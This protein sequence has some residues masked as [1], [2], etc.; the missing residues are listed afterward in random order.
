MYKQVNR[1]LETT[2][3][4]VGHTLTSARRAAKQGAHGA[5]QSASHVTKSARSST[6][7]QLGSIA[8]MVNPDTHKS[9][10]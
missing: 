7:R 1:A 4:Q 9:K 8:D 5:Q 6:A 2:S 3:K 10:R